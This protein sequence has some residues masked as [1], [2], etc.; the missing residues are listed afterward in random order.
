MSDGYT[1][2]TYRIM[3]PLPPEPVLYKTYS[4]A[5]S[6]LVWCV[7]ELNII[8]TTMADC[9]TRIDA[10]CAT[11]PVFHLGVKRIIDYGGGGGAVW[12]S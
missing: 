2:I 4:I 10:V 1:A 5:P 11:L 12:L 7:E 3:D 8:G 6:G 9:R